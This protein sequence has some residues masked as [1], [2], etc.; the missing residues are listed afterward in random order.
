MLRARGQPRRRPGLGRSVLVR[1]GRQSAER[2]VPG[3]WVSHPAPSTFSLA[4]DRLGW[5]LEQILASGLHAAPLPA[6]G[7]ILG[8]GVRAIVLLRD[9][10]AAADLPMA[11]ENG[12]GRSALTVLE[13]LGGPRERITRRHRGRRPE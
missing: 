4:A 11:G 9:G 13:A 3:E 2:S 1:R 8:R 10:A 12:F 7:R 6:C 5:R